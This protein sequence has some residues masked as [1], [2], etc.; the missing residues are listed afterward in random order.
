MEASR[1]QK[2]KRGVMTNTVIPARSRRSTF[3]P[4]SVQHIVVGF[5]ALRGSLLHSCEDIV[6]MLPKC[7]RVKHAL[8]VLSVNER[9]QRVKG[10]WSEY[11]GARLSVVKSY[12]EVA[13]VVVL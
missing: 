8:P 1:G 5:E 2:E 10:R 6:E 3:S 4:R 9:P 12:P 11:W 13:Q 7:I